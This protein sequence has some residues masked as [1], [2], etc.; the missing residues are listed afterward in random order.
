MASDI[1]LQER[2]MSF[3]QRCYQMHE[4]R[5]V[6]VVRKKDSNPM[7]KCVGL[8]VGGEAWVNSPES[9]LHRKKVQVVRLMRNSYLVDVVRDGQ[10]YTFDGSELEAM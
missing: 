1:R 9:P 4:L 7:R 8:T 2:C 6:P 5:A 10:T 3:E